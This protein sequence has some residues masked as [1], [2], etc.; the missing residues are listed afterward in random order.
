MPGMAEAARRLASR[1]DIVRHPEGDTPRVPPFDAIE[2][3]VAGLLPPH[4]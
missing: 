4:E 2:R 3:H 1:D